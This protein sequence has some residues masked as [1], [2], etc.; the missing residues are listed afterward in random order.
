[1]LSPSR[2]GFRCRDPHVLALG[3]RSVL[4]DGQGRSNGHRG[5]RFHSNR[6][7]G[8]GRRLRPAAPQQAVGVFQ[9]SVQTLDIVRRARP[10]RL[11]FASDAD[12]RLHVGQVALPVELAE[13]PDLVRHVVVLGGRN[14]AAPGLQRQ[15]QVPHGLLLFLRARSEQEAGQVRGAPQF[16]GVVDAEVAVSHQVR[17]GAGKLL[18]AALHVAASPR[19]ELQR[20]RAVLL[21]TGPPP[22][23]GRSFSIPPRIP[24]C[25]PSPRRWCC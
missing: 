1:M 7:R 16:L 11:R 23:A 17:V 14:H 25:S 22:R 12:V 3:G 9:P 4:A 10:Q 19:G 8:G 5:F 21:P 13:E 2:P 15:F 6:L 20:A 18:G 24:G